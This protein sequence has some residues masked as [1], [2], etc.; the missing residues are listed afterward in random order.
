MKKFIKIFTLF[1]ICI[2]ISLSCIAC[3]KTNDPSLNPDT[4]SNTIETTQT[5]KSKKE[6]IDSLTNYSFEYQ[7]SYQED[8]TTKITSYIDMRTSDS[9][10]YIVEKTAFLANINTQS[11][12][13][14]D[15]E[16]KTA[17]LTDLDEDMTSFST[18]GTVL[19]GWYE[20]A[21]LF[22]KKGSSTIVGRACDVHEYNLGTL[23]YVYYLDKEYDICLKYEITASPTQ[24]TTFEFTEFKIGD[25]L[26]QEVL[27]ILDGYQIDD[28]RGLA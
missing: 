21:S 18:W 8:E 19:F 1:T 2:V 14:L 7:I 26:T 28:Y 24:K 20:H 17:T 15:L 11:L 27:S 12:Y 25:I 5:F 6:V 13:M 9:W 3:K 22:S 16:G 10:L 4:L 23:K